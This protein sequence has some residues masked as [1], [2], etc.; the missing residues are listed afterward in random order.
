[1]AAGDGGGKEMRVEILFVA[2]GARAAREVH[3]NLSVL[4]CNWSAAAKI[5]S[6]SSLVRIGKMGENLIFHGVSNEKALTKLEAMGFAANYRGVRMSF[7][8]SK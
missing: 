1:M 7:A 6:F 4:L 3:E 8:A 5:F 2:S